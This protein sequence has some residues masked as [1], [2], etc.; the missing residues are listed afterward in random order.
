F[1]PESS[2]S[3]VRA[4]PFGHPRTEGSLQRIEVIENR[5]PAPDQMTSEP[6]GR[7]CAACAFLT[8]DAIC[9]RGLRCCLLPTAMHRAKQVLRFCA[10]FLVAGAVIAIAAFVTVE[11]IPPRFDRIGW[12]MDYHQLREHVSLYYPGLAWQIES[13]RLDPYE[14]NSYS[15]RAVLGARSDLEAE[16]AIRRFVR[17]FRDPHFSVERPGGRAAIRE[18]RERTHT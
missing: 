1:A 6:R 14:V 12:F 2:P 18:R 13:G 9:P 8:P 3:P 7:P 16:Q 17:A 10:V 4:P 15:L 5:G 11:K